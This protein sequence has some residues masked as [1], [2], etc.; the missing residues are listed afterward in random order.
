MLG[1]KTKPN[2]YNGLI[3]ELPNLQ[4]QIHEQKDIYYF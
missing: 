4:F 2:Y 1:L 3:W